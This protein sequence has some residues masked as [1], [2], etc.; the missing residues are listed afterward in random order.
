V[1]ASECT[2]R[3]IRYVPS[4]KRDRAASSV[5]ATEF[6]E[7]NRRTDLRRRLLPQDGDTIPNIEV[8]DPEDFGHEG[9]SVLWRTWYR[10]REYSESIPKPMIPIGHQPIS[11]ISCNI[12]AI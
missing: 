7:R 8:M 11:G 1:S 4:A 6:E 10:I 5:P 12:T 2:F 3:S 9:C